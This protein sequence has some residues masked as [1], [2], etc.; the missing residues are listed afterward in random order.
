M[1]PGFIFAGF[2]SAITTPLDTLKTRVQSSGMKDY[3]ILKGMADIYLREG[4][5]GLF[6][7]VQWR[8]LK[9]SSHTS[10]YLFLYEWYMKRVCSTDMLIAN[11]EED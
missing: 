6:A 2:C 9:N 8:V 11:L 7:G 4:I 3:K 1:L 10:M 5:K